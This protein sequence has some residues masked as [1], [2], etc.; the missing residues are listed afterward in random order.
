MSTRLQIKVDYGFCLA[1]SVE[2]NRA[3]QNSSSRDPVP[4]VKFFNVVLTEIT[5][6]NLGV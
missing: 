5:K 2:Q 1:G 6:I 4:R 3:K